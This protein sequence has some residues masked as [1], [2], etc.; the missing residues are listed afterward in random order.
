[1]SDVCQ[2]LVLTLDD[3]ADTNTPILATLT[4]KTLLLILSQ[5]HQDTKHTKSIQAALSVKENN[6]SD[7][8]HEHNKH[9]L[10]SE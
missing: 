2:S 10:F 7:T 8:V 4:A 3:I 6:S 5:A 1:M 9:H